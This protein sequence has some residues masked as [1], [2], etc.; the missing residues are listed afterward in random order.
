MTFMERALSLARRAL[1]DTSPNPAVGAVVVKDGRV[2]GEGWTQPAGQAHA[3]VE[4]L[5]RAGARADGATLYT[6]LEPCNHFGRTPPC[7]QAIIQAGISEVHAAATDPNPLV[8]GAG[9]S[10]LAEAGVETKVG[11]GELEARELMEAYTKFITSGTPLITA[12]FAMSL[13]GKIATRTGDSKWITGEEARRYVHQLRATSDA[14]MAGINTVIADDP[15]LT[16]RDDS[17]VP[18]PRQPLRVLVD[19]R[20]RPPAEAK[21]LSE[22][23]RT[24]VVVSNADE[25][26]RE[27]L[28]EAGAEVE[29]LPGKDGHVDL[30]ALAGVLGRRDITSVFVEGGGTLLGSLFDEGLVDKVVAFVSPAIVG[31]AAALSPVGGQGVESM[32]DALRLTR[33]SVMHFGE[34]LAVIGYCGEEDVHGDS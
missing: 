3:E 18:E 26:A 7:T 25:T 19:S 2:V 6:T 29:S 21:V 12:K 4:A 32:G 31:G 28:A 15:R 27:R 34:D 16:A 10:A 24:L 30:T 20:G 22:P 17:G 9:M 1:G 11:E 5:R 23:G 8:S 13:D 33:T 14:I